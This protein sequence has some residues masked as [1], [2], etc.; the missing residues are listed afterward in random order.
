M[1]PSA[2]I[3]ACAVCAVLASVA[4][5]QTPDERAA[6]RDVLSK[7]EGAVVT[8]HASVVLRG[9]PSRGGA[10]RMED[11]VQANAVVL[12]G[13]G[14]TVTALSQLDP[15][16]M[17]KRALA[18]VPGVP[19]MNISVAH[20]NVRL[21]LGNGQEVPAKIVLRDPDLDLAFLRPT[22]APVS[23]MASIDMAAAARVQVTDLVIV[24]QRFGE[25]TGWKT[26]VSIGSVQAVVEKPRTQYVVGVPSVCAMKNLMP[27]RA[28]V[29]VARA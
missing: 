10:D 23:P 26:G 1:R 20:S 28:M 14:L 17:L 5:A 7:R 2:L 9:M 15:S 8:V 11:V 13:S 29:T 22:E 6:A 3:A 12:D 18:G 21:R 19:A 24:L 4:G 27:H 25:M 16:D